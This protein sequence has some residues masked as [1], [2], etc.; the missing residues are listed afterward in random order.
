ML[1]INDEI[2]E[3]QHARR[4]KTTIIHKRDD[5]F[6]TSG[7]TLFQELSLGVRS[8]IALWMRLLRDRDGF[9]TFWPEFHLTFPLDGTLVL[10]AKK[11]SSKPTS[12]FI[13]SSK[14]G[15]YT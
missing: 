10:S 4:E 11:T 2:S 7:E 3:T 14:K 1:I 6:S 12:T 9:N 5:Y 15:E 8:G 13:L